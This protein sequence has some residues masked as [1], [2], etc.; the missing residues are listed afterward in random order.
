MTID[1]LVMISSA[2]RFEAGGLLLK[3]WGQAEYEP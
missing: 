2:M 3:R 1:V